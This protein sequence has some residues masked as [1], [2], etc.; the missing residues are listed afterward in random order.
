[1]PNITPYMTQKHFEVLADELAQDKFFYDSLIAFHE[2]LDRMIKY[3]QDSNE[4]FDVKKFTDR[5]DLTYNAFDKKM[6]AQV[7]KVGA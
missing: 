4:R 3:C 5:I 6:R 7:Q 1:M 2:K